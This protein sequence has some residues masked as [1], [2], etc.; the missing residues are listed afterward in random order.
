MALEAVTDGT[1]GA[2]YFHIENSANTNHALEANTNSN[3]GGSALYGNASTTTGYADGVTGMAH[4]YS[5]VGGRFGNDGEG[6]ALW[7]SATGNGAD[8][9][10]LSDC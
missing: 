9:A 2:G 7:A 5:S 4:A 10:A 6:V 8:R 1:G 3:S